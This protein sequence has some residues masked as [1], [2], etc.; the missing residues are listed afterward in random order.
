MVARLAGAAF[1]PYRVCLAAGPPFPTRS[2]HLFVFGE[3]VGLA[4][5]EARV[6][7]ANVAPFDPSA[8]QRAVR[9][10][11]WYPVVDENKPWSAPG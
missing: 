8:A 10:E 1:C 6:W 2:S 11:T 9:I 4:V 5:N 7:I 3:T